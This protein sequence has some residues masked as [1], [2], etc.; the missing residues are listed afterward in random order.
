MEC[1]RDS[2]TVSLNCRSHSFLTSGINLLRNSLLRRIFATCVSSAP[3]ED[4][5]VS[6]A[7]SVVNWWWFYVCIREIVQSGGTAVRLWSEA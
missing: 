5:V 4:Q 7:V 3:G 6:I 2:S 1:F